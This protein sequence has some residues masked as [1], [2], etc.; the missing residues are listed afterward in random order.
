[1]DEVF[2]YASFMWDPSSSL[3]QQESPDMTTTIALDTNIIV[4]VSEYTHTTF[5]GL[6]EGQMIYY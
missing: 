6:Q 1:M 2:D 4:S 5:C 3:W